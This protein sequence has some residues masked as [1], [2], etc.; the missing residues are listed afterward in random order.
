MPK[1]SV[2]SLTGGWTAL[3]MALSVIGSANGESLTVESLQETYFLLEPIVIKVTLHLDEPLRLV[4]DDPIEASRQHRELRRHLAVEFRNDDGLVYETRLGALSF[5]P[6]DDLATDVLACL[7]VMPGELI[8]EKNESRFRFWGS[9]GIYRVRVHDREH[10]MYSN[11]VLIRFNEPGADA[12]EAAQLFQAGGTG[13]LL[14]LHGAERGVKARSLLENLAAAHGH[15]V[16]GKY[17]RA[18]LAVMR[19]PQGINQDDQDYAEGLAAA[20][21]DLKLVIASFRPAHTMRT[22]ALI[23]LAELRM[24]SLREDDA[25]AV[26]EKLFRE[27]ADISMVRSAHELKIRIEH[28]KASRENSQR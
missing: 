27:T 23:R 26:I 15:T 28:A 18:C 22:R 16:Y 21:A 20:E 2:H 11:D 19:R 24:G 5:L 6:W 9:S 7:L 12:R 4:H 10:E 3:F 8:P 1:T 14:A 13:L 17:A 25:A